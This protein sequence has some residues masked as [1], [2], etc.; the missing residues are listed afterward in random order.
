MTCRPPTR[1]P[2]LTLTEVLVAMFI[3]ALG[4]ISLL[5]LFPLGAIQIGL[6][7]RDDRLKQTAVQADTFMR[8][9][10]RAK[11]VEPPTYTVILPQPPQPPDDFIWGFDSP[12]QLTNPG[13][14][15]RVPDPSYAVLVDPIGFYSRTGPDQTVVAASTGGAN[16]GRR[17][18]VLAWTYDPMTLTYTS[19]PF[20]Q[21]D[22]LRN[23]TLLDDITFAPNGVPEQTS[24]LITR[25]GRYNWAAIVQKPHNN[26]PNVS[27]TIL[28]FSERPPLLNVADAERAITVPQTDVA[29][30]QPYI[31]N[32][33]P[34]LIEP[35]PSGLPPL[36]RKGG[37]IMD[38]TVDPM[39]LPTPPRPHAIR[40][41]RI[42]GISDN[43]A[44]RLRL[45][46]D[47][48]YAGPLPTTAG[49]SLTFYLFS[50]LTEVFQR[51]Q[52]PPN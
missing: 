24:S 20:G 47:P 40:F 18:M 8:A 16:M 37:W 12:T 30:D 11:V 46:I 36:I 48:P 43:G 25:Q 34:V 1:R 52:L 17:N 49:A 51:P 35:T 41:Y 13:L 21:L 22:A 33:D 23:C 14:I 6:A 19:T 31:D 3:M 26:E 38:G 28:C 10:W 32:I 5:T 9:H 44:G 45:D 7:L 42:I 27:L 2:G 50:G 39:T 15:V 4:M 29:V